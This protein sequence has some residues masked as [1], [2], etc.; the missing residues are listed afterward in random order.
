MGR[1]LLNATADLTAS[2]KSDIVLRSTVAS[3]MLVSLD[4]MSASV[5]VIA[6]LLCLTLT[7]RLLFLEPAFPFPREPEL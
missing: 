3:S 2:R 1:E 5:S 7:L 4:R 6:Q